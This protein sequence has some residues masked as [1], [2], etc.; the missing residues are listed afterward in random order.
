[1]T[2]LGQLGRFVAVGALGEMLYLMMFFAASKQGFAP[3]QAVAMAGG[4]CMLI[5]A[6]LHAR[7]SFRSRNSLGKT[8]RYAGIQTV[9]LVVSALLAQLLGVLGSGSW[10]IGLATAASWALLSFLLTRRLHQGVDHS[11]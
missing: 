10:L 11:S 2:G 9:C 3:G 5:N 1:M 4:L 6:E 7:F 8:L